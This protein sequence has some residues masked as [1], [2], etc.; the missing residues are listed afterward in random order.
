MS[1]GGV[2]G[3]EEAVGEKWYAI[4]MVDCMEKKDFTL[5]IDFSDDMKS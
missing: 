4:L 1:T 5:F 3:R 2:V